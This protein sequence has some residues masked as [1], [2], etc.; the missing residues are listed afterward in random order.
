MRILLGAA[1]ALSLAF[2][3]TGCSNEDLRQADARLAVQKTVASRGG[4]SGDVHCT[5]NPKPWFVEQEA[6][7]FVCVARRDDR[8]CDWFRASLENAGWSVALERR[9]GG[10]V[11]PF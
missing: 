2:G 5:G 11:A 9:N 4:Y 1:V 8:G 3:L 6:T 10:C 7:V